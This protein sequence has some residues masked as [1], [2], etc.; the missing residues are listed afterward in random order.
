MEACCMVDG[1]CCAGIWGVGSTIIKL[2]WLAEREDGP[3]GVIGCYM[4][5]QVI[6]K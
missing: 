4:M 5:I 6:M 3:Q 1:W 2:L